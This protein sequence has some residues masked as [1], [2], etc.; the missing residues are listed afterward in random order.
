M[1]FS[2]ATIISLATSVL[3]MPQASPSGGALAPKDGPPPSCQTS[4]EGNFGITVVELGKRSLETRTNCGQKGSL[5][6]TLKNGV[7][8]DSQGRIGSIVANYQFQFDGPP[9][10]DAIYT[11]GFSVCSNGSLALGGSTTFYRC[12]SGNFY[13]LY[14]RHWAEQCSPIH[15]SVL[16]CGENA[17]I[18]SG[19]NV[20][21]TTMVATALV[22]VIEDGQP[23][24]IPTTIPIP[25]CQIGDGQIQGHTTPCGE[26]PPVTKTRPPAPPA[27]QP[28][29]TPPVTVV[30]PPVTTPA[31]PPPVQTPPVQT[32]SRP[33]TPPANTSVPIRPPASTTPVAPPVAAG[34]QMVPATF[35]AVVAGLMAVLYMI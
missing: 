23:Q 28:P 21:G 19:G 7:L 14:D 27:S 17:P 18:P 15:L 30:P 25:I 8:T 33:P 3:A 4:Y 11:S 13:N 34:Q 1:K 22:T 9:Q 20:V 32:P 2:V 31:V 16:P 35:M 12:L 26:I 10:V 29:Y 6:L 24:V 5:D